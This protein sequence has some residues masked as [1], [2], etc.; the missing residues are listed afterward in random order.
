MATGDQGQIQTH[1]LV[2]TRRTRFA[3]RWKTRENSP[4]G[5]AL[6]RGLN[7]AEKP[8]ASSSSS[9]LFFGSHVILFSFLSRRRAFANQVDTCVSVILVM[10]ASMIFSPLVG[11]GFFLCSFSHAFS[12][13]VDS[14]VAFFRRAA[15]S[16]PA[17]YLQV[18]STLHLACRGKGT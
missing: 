18:F 15:R 11:Y 10:I 16:Y 4:F 6:N 12:V 3:S 5:S 7:E 13:A 17:P 14:R 9:V 8:R 2:G 1:T